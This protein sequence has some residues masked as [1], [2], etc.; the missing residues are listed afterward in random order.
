MDVWRGTCRASKATWTSLGIPGEGT[1][2]VLL[3]DRRWALC[4]SQ[5]DPLS[6]SA[7]LNVDSTVCYLSES[8]KNENS[9]PLKQ[10]FPPLFR[11]LE[12]KLLVNVDS[13]GYE[14]FVH[15]GKI[16]QAST[17]SVLVTTPLVVNPIQR[18]RLQ[19][20]FTG[21][22]VIESCQIK[23][24]GGLPIQ[25]RV[26]RTV[27]S[28][29]FLLCGKDT[30]IVFE[31]PVPK[32]TEVASVADS[33]FKQ[34][35]DRFSDPTKYIGFE[36]LSLPRGIILIG[37]PGVGKSHSVSELVN[38][39]KAMNV[40]V[41][42]QRPSPGDFADKR[43]GEIALATLFETGRKHCNNYPGGISIIF[44][45][46]I[47]SYA[48]ARSSHESR[49]NHT[50]HLLTLMDGF[51]S[52]DSA[53][54]RVV[55]LAATNR[56][57]A[58][59]PAMRRPGRFDK[60]IVL[61]LPTA[62]ERYKFVLSVVP[63]AFPNREQLAEYVQQKCVGYSQADMIA[64]IRRSGNGLQ[65]NIPLFSAAALRDTTQLSS[66]EIAGLNEIGG[67]ESTK[68]ELKQALEWPLVKRDH[69]TR[70]G[71]SNLYRG[72]LLY[73]P[74]G[75]AK[76]SLV[77]SLVAS[78]AGKVGFYAMSGAD[79]YSSGFGDAEAY[80][81]QAF[82]KA[83][84]TAPSVLF[85]DEVDSLVGSR[86]SEKDSGN[87]VQSRV[88]STFLNEMDGITTFGADNVL[89]IGAT[90]SPESIDSALLRPGRF[91]RL[92]FVG[93][94]D[95][96]T[97]LKVETT[98]MGLDSAIDV[99]EL[100]GDA[101]DMSGAEIVGACRIAAMSALQRGFEAK[102]TQEDFRN[103]LRNGSRSCRPEALARYR[104]FAEITK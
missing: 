58:L 23:K 39:L 96:I 27:P 5:A 57:G 52:K 71:L 30:R 17:V 42:F 84:E 72:V 59:D 61:K 81:R 40:P 85:F 14:L 56:I 26:R 76:T 69:L 80:V 4:S 6:V 89:V 28:G 25:G 47:D 32:K 46:E 49:A 9:I 54:H 104:R 1:F 83:R 73:G 78:L 16:Q 95:P 19:A 101:L 45:D 66:Q 37:P 33:P 51:F 97:V 98:R 38:V 55:I 34:I 65:N 43:S 22:V 94:P 35:I 100:A 86:D 7:C 13:N 75:C 93:P 90:N 11:G 64:L 67:Q 31:D 82:A 92:L 53:N 70:M 87:S 102:P 20:W 77:R 62:E 2:V 29:C 103:A 12:Q 18:K 79:V 8:D 3:R 24:I 10:Q 41:H 91:D 63:S 74:P 44:L 36:T 50:A 48:F 60:E 21:L 68:Q 99:E 88:L 15:N